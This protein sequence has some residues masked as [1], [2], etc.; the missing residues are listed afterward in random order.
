MG[1]TVEIFKPD[2]RIGSSIS[3]IS[4]ISI[5]ELKKEG[6]CSAFQSCGPLL[7]V[8][9]Q[10]IEPAEDYIRLDGNPTTNSNQ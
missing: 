2:V 7:G 8:N 10:E 4:E 5:Q 9:V 6:G 3:R 1:L